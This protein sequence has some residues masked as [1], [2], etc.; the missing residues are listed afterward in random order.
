MHLRRVER[1]ALRYIAAVRTSRD[2]RKS[3]PE[4]GNRADLPKV[5]PDGMPCTVRRLYRHLRAAAQQRAHASACAS[6]GKPT[7][8]CAS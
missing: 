5:G 8:A 3:G 2:L 1:L 7:A 4:L 6:V